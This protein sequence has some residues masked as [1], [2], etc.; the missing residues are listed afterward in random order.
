MNVLI[1][2]AHPEEKSLSAA[3]RD[4]AIDELKAQGHEVKISD[5]YADGWKAVVDREDFPTLALDERLKVPAASGQAL[6][7]DSLTPDVKA[8]QEK[9][10]WAD[11]VLV[12]FPLWWF[13]M[14]AILKGWVDR[15]FSY[16]FAYGVGEHTATRWG[17][18]YGEGRMAGKRAMLLV[19]TGGWEA[20]YGARGINGP[21]DDL[22]FPINHGILFYPGF[23]VL[24]PY[25]TYKA[26][27]LSPQDFE[28]E[29]EALRERIRGLETTR[30]IPYR[31]QNDGDYLMPSMNLRPELGDPE[32][33]GFSLHLLG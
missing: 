2:F 11:T 17:D 7:T 30:P 16:G 6:A 21:I 22:L 10:L 28:T 13:T 1:V 25:I 32:M 12:Q 15:V 23:D 29:A 9:L 5:L 8:E 4:T 26:D 3:L 27:R 14:P 18:R 20:H 33:S 31:R 19:T 24:P